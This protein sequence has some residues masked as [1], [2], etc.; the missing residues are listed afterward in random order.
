M[1]QPDFLSQRQQRWLARGET[2][3]HRETNPSRCAWLV[4]AGLGTV[5]GVGNTDALAYDYGV[6]PD[7]LLVLDSYAASASPEHRLSFFVAAGELAPALAVS[8]WFRWD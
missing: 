6:N 8:N 1:N 2:L 5:L 7:P 3:N 4:C